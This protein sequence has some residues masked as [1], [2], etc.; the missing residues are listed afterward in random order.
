MGAGVSGWLLAN[1]VAK[2]GQLGVVS[3]TA[4]DIILVRRLQAG[5]PGEHMRRALAHFPI[6][7][8]ANRIVEK[9]YIEGGKAATDSFKS[10]SMF[11][12]NPSIEL[13][14]LTVAANFVEV[15]LAKEGHN[16]VVGINYLEKIQMP[17]IY[18]I[19][20]AM[21]AGV[22]Y[23]L[24]GAGI[25]REIPG[26]L[27]RLSNHEEVSLSLN[28]DGAD[29][30]D[31]FRMFFD[32]KKVTGKELP[33]LK[34]PNFLAII[35]S[36]ILA[37]TLA[38]KSTG[39]VDGFIIEGPIAGGHNAMPRGAL[40]LSERGEPLYG[41]KDVVDIEKI[42]GLGLPFWLAGSYGTAEKLKEA[43]NSGAA[44]VQVGTAFAFCKESGLTEEIRTALLDK[45]IKGTAD[46]FTDPHAS[47]TNF[48]F[49]VVRLEG[50]N[51]EADVFEA[52]PRICDLGYLRHLYKKEDGTVGYRCP[53]EPVEVYVKRGGS[54]EDTVG[55]KCLCNG[56]MA[57]IGLP[58]L[59]KGYLE[60]PLVT[61]GED[62]KYLGRF[63]KQG[64]KT[65]S[66]V[67]VINSMLENKNAGA[68]VPCS[69]DLT[70]EAGI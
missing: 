58:Q 37:I 7:E 10:C 17:N 49:K 11:S 40:K 68:S 25:P 16:G 43:L 12:A 42:K 65:Y 29:K 61:A 13:Q 1:S 21:L 51:S 59:R 70:T 56:L 35:A 64:E 55:R 62:L 30:E 36:D 2:A 46:V 48:P 20:G 8:I 31:D 67:D 9:Y 52:R 22:D 28:V 26:I 44:G 6:P 23:V 54:A 3:G 39:K 5:D 38:K 41:P 57:N 66:A 69:N 63:I 27:D 33:V 4:L 45:V 18:S 15:Y 47:P 14:E 60:K 32:P 24:M 53:S 34:R 19:Y 50:T